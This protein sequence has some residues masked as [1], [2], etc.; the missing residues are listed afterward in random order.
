MYIC[1]I[2]CH[3]Y[4]SDYTEYVSDIFILGKHWRIPHPQ[5]YNSQDNDIPFT[6]EK[7]FQ[8]KNQKTALKIIFQYKRQ[9]TFFP[10]NEG[11]GEWLGW[12]GVFGWHLWLAWEMLHYTHTLSPCQLQTHIHNYMQEKAS[13][14]MLL[15]LECVYCVWGD[16]VSVLKGCF[17]VYMG[18]PL[19]PD[20]SSSGRTVMSNLHVKSSS[21]WVLP[22]DFIPCLFWSTYRVNILTQSFSS[23][24]YKWPNQH[25]LSVQCSV[26]LLIVIAFF[27]PSECH[28]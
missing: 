27:C 6:M 23:F 16:V 13:C 19:S 24:L 21:F 15:V 22:Q 11:R 14:S 3:A 18:Q 5:I 2:N 8:H 9:P 25:N 28:K 20:G 4:W 17:S 10:E 12:W 26:Y 7:K 1:I